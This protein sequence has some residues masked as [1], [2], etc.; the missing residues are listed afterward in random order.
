MFDSMA[1]MYVLTI[2]ITAKNTI[3]EV[4]L[5]YERDTAQCRA[6]LHVLLTGQETESK[7][8]IFRVLKPHMV[9]IQ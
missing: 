2:I 3:V 9:Q 7:E 6:T 1:L 5:I 8:V 4:M